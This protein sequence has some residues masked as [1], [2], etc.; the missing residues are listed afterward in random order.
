M[1]KQK[2][3]L[4]SSII[5]AGMESISQD[6]LLS[7][8][9]PDKEP[10]RYSLNFVTTKEFKGQFKAW[11]ARKNLNMTDAFEKGFTLLKNKYGD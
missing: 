1:A 10:T 5:S 4:S 7:Q 2:F 11:C 8:E 3:E 6:S 9:K